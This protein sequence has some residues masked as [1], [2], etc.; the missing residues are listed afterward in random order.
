[1]F[2]FLDDLADLGRQISERPEAKKSK[3]AAPQ[4]PASPSSGGALGA[5][6]GRQVGE[7]T[8]R[9]EERR[10]RAL[11]EFLQLTPYDKP[12][13]AA[14]E[15]KTRDLT[16]EDITQRVASNFTGAREALE[17][18]ELG[19]FIESLRKYQAPSKRDS[20]REGGGG[21]SWGVEGAVEESPVSET[22]KRRAVALTWE[23]YDALSP[24]QRAAVDF[25]TMLV[26]AREKDLNTDYKATGTER[27]AYQREVEA[28][29]GSDRGS[30]TFAPETLAVLKQLDY[31]AS[32][33]EDFD[34]FLAL[35]MTIDRRQLRNL[36]LDTEGKSVRYR[37]GSVE[38]SGG[39]EGIDQLVTNTAKLREALVR[40]NQ[41]LQD[42]HTTAAAMR[43]QVTPE[44]GG[45][46]NKVRAAFG[47]GSG[48]GRRPQNAELDRMFQQAFRTLAAKATPDS[49]RA[50]LWQAAAEEFNPR[51]LDAFVRYVDERT[52]RMREYNIG[53]VGDEAEDRQ[54]LP[55][56]E[57]RAKI[58]LDGGG[59]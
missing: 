7:D 22:R 48:E 31:R 46:E 10:Q 45:E 11:D 32:G 42:F 5:L 8:G 56:E 3:P 4:R 23:E 17:R 53:V 12:L 13:P 49:V 47:F 50:E 41:M 18:G 1:M 29:F 55:A 58:G 38:V 43:N 35:D 28:M 15:A 27:A 16:F 34:D 40:G 2:D 6:L 37:D 39:L 52:R 9:Q 26:Q 54:Y 21:G 19:S 57:I 25:N 24:Q 14:R 30:E 36:E 44:L 33:D 51:Q 20:L 59:R